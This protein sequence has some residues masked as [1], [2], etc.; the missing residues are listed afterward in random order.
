MFQTARHFL[1]LVRFS[2]TLFALPFALLACGP[3]TDKRVAARWLSVWFVTP[4]AGRPGSLGFRPLFP[5]H[6]GS[7]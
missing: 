4:G 1:S 7:Y 3:I 5:G 2:H 6:D